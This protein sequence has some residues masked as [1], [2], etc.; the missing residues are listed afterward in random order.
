MQE[1]LLDH[2]D[3]LLLDALQRNSDTTNA[4][5]SEAIHLSVSQISRRRQR[6]EEEGIIAQFVAMLDQKTVGLGVTAFAHVLLESHSRAGPEA[7]ANAIM[8]MPEILEC[9][10]VSGDADY[11]LRIVAPDLDSFS[12]LMMNR[13][14]HLPN[15]AHIKTSIALQTIKQTHILPLDH[16]PQPRKKGRRVRF[17]GGG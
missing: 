4:D 8:A 6:L 9:H 15:V 3:L 14:L 11:I 16:I 5:L 7:F 2:Y 13:I 12:D 1:I 17:S 10:S